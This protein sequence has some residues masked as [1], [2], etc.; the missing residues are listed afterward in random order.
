[1]SVS[2][3]RSTLLSHLRHEEDYRRLNFPALPNETL[4]TWLWFCSCTTEAR[5]SD[6]LFV[7]QGDPFMSLRHVRRRAAAIFADPGLRANVLALAGGK[8]IGLALVVAAMKIFLPTA[9]HAQAQPP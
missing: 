9:L 4:K 8:I 1:M 3:S 2:S 7:E 5:H 6:A